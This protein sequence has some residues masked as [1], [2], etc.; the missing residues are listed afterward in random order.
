MCACLSKEHRVLASDDPDTQPD[1]GP[2][3][4]PGLGS[5]GKKKKE[6]KERLIIIDKP[7]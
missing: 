1:C 7:K 3:A 2:A 4:E 5:G 6:G